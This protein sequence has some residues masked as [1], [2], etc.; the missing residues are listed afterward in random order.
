MAPLTSAYI[1]S[2]FIAGRRRRPRRI[3]RQCPS[4]SPSPPASLPP[5]PFLKPPPDQATTAT[6][7]SAPETASYTIQSST[8]PQEGSTTTD[9]AIM[10]RQYADRSVNVGQTCKPTSPPDSLSPFRWRM[11]VA[12]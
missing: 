12:E 7:V 2:L 1:P 6:A 5:L 10:M 8:N 11:H 9:F 4:P 3:P